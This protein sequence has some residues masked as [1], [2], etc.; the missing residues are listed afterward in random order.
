MVLGP[1]LMHQ[2]RK[3]FDR[4]VPLLELVWG[5]HES[6]KKGAFAGDQA[7]RDKRPP[8][9]RRKKMKKASSHHVSPSCTMQKQAVTPRMWR[10]K[11]LGLHSESPTCGVVKTTT[12]LVGSSL[13]PFAGHAIQVTIELRGSACFIRPS[14]T[15]VRMDLQVGL[16]GPTMF[17]KGVSIH[18]YTWNP[19]M[20]SVLTGSWTIFWVV[21]GPK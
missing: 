11:H 20:S 19:D 3:A 1:C 18:I 12:C 6:P 10:K 4:T 16:E 13:G 9:Q 8:R 14:H 17:S 21:G 5:L 7:F 2:K 15:V